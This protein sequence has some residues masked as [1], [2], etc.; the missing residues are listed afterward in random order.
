MK[1][2]PVF[3]L[4]LI[5]FPG[6]RVN[7]HIFEPRYKKL[8]SDIR[9]TDRR[10]GISPFVDEK[11]AE[12]GTET[13]VISIARE[14]P[15]GEMDITVEGK[16][17]YRITQFF[18]S[19]HPDSYANAEIT[20]APH[21]L[22]GGDPYMYAEILKYLEQLFEVLKLDRA[23]PDSPFS[24]CCYDVAHVAGM[25]LN[26][27]YELLCIPDE[28]GRQK[29]MLD[30]LKTFLPHAHKVQRLK[31]LAALNGHFRNLKLD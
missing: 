15:G 1:L 20:Y 14:Y 16:E 2:I 25:S 18:E 6:E 27:E 24:Y 10:F 28:A 4:R 11:L 17:L 7:L 12:T 5:V 21:T 9:N 8:I 22:E 29:Y 19:S 31:Q 13:E 26:E 3:P 30:H 23:L